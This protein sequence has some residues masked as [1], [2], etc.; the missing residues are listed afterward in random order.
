MY[1]LIF[2]LFLPATAR[3]QLGLLLFLLELVHH[4]L[5]GLGGGR[6]VPR[7]LHRVLAWGEIFFSITEF[8]NNRLKHVSLISLPFPCVRPLS[9]AENPNILLRGTSASRENQSSLPV[10][11]VMMPDLL[12]MMLK[13]CEVNS[14][15]LFTST[16]ITGS[17]ICHTPSTHTSPKADC[18]AW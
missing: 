4:L 15:G 7:V 17:R 8:T 14:W 5:L 10:W 6:R 9:S 12:L 16:L 1:H 13:T 2:L 3:G 11:P 18:E